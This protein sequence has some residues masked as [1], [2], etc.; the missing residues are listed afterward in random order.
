[1]RPS[2]SLTGF[3]RVLVDHAADLLGG[4]VIVV[5]HDD[6]VVEQVVRAVGVDIVLADHTLG[7]GQLQLGDRIV[8]SG[9]IG[10]PGHLDRILDDPDAV[11][12]L[13]CAR[14]GLFTEL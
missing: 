14:V 5:L 8:D 13:H 6:R 9:G 1:Q 3:G 7:G 4:A 10:R 11:V 2:S 12:R